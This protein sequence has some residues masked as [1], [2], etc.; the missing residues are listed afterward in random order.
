MTRICI[1]YL[2]TDQQHYQVWIRNST[3]VLTFPCSKIS[4]AFD[5]S[6]IGP[7]DGCAKKQDVMIQSP[8]PLRR[9]SNNNHIE[10][11][12][13]V[14]CCI[15]PRTCSPVAIFTRH[16]FERKAWFCACFCGTLFSGSKS[17]SDP[18]LATSP[19]SEVWGR[20][21]CS[22]KTNKCEFVR[23]KMYRTIQVATPLAL[24]R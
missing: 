3:I 12:W 24:S 19:S 21:T 16:R 18:G 20:A 6:T 14:D 11:W 22:V 15:R 1:Q 17:N 9:C 13:A 4:I 5:N 7:Q 10:R 8:N 23:R 2:D